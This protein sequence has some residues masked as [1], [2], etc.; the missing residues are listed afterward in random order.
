MYTCLIYRR[1]NSVKSQCVIV[2]LAGWWL[3]EGV[4]SVSLDEIWVF[5]SMLSCLVCL[6]VSC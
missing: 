4:E 6:R 2:V 1:V 3:V 5:V